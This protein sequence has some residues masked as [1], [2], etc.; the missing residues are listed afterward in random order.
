M[1]I[2]LVQIQLVQSQKYHASRSRFRAALYSFTYTARLHGI[3]PFNGIS[4][5]M[6]LFTKPS[7]ICTTDVKL[8]YIHQLKLF[9]KRRGKHEKCQ[10]AGSQHYTQ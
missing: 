5:T 2:Q 7:H 1:K 3:F 10:K 4:H 8:E 9:G 6:W